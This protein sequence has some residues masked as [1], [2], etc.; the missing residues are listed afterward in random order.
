MAEEKKKP[1]RKIFLILGLVG[2]ALFVTSDKGKELINKHI[3]GIDTTV[4]CECGDV[5][6]C[7]ADCECHGEGCSCPT[8]VSDK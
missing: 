6:D 5:C 2:L 7:K 1:R 4:V 3:K 8:C